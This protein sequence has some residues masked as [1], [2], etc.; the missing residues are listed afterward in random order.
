[1]RQGVYALR[2]A[3]HPLEDAITSWLAVDRARLPWERGKEAV[4][5]LSHATA[6]SLHNLGTITPQRPALTVQPR[7]RSTSRARGIELHVARLEPQDWMWLRADNA[8][9][10]PTTT[11]ARTIVDLV[12][13]G[14]ETSYVI[15]TIREALED[16]RLSPQELVAAARRRKQRS[17][18]LT[19]RVEA[20]L[21]RAAS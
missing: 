1:V 15:R 13:A 16:D 11:P 6:A 8:L 18:A 10:L 14:E 20:L 3:R 4:A 5:V 17:A 19:K 2:H 9:L 7:L 12:T 21:A